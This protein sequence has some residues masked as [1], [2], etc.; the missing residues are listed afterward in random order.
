MRSN[1][2]KSGP[3]PISNQTNSTDEPIIPGQTARG[4]VALLALVHHLRPQEVPL[5]ADVS[6]D[7]G[8]G[9]ALRRGALSQDTFGGVAAP[10]AGLADAAFPALHEAV[11][12][13]ADVLDPRAPRRPPVQHVDL[14][15]G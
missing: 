4:H 8:V 1:L 3:N 6:L 5:V 15:V 7:G 9:H 12:L 13:L 10:A 14:T 11:V 2:M